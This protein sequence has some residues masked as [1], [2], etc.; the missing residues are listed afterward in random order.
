MNLDTR[1][2]SIKKFL[3]SSVL[4][5]TIVLTTIGYSN[6]VFAATVNC[7]LPASL[8]AEGVCVGTAQADTISGTTNDDEIAGGPG[9]DG[10]NAANGDDIVSGNAGSDTLDGQQGDDIVIG[11]AGADQ[12]R[13]GQGDD[14]T[15]GGA[16]NDNIRGGQGSDAVFGGAGDDTLNGNQNA[17]GINCGTGQNDIVDAFSLTED[18][19]IDASGNPITVGT[20]VAQATA[21]GCEHV[22]PF[23]P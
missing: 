22:P 6:N 9:N 8:N 4:V 3:M 7:A 20:P 17:D 1:S 12:V 19:F 10:I 16:G 15:A 5:V 23:K 13:G 21:A 2:N 11:G 18:V 14:E